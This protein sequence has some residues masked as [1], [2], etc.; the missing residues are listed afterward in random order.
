MILE[1]KKTTVAYR[2]PSCG[3]V[4]KSMVGVFALKAD[5][6]RLKCPCGE[7]DMTIEYKREGKIKLTVP[8]FLCPRPHVFTVSENIFFSKELFALPCGNTGI[9]IAFLGEDKEVNVA[10]DDSDRM[11]AELFDEVDF[12]DVS[13]HNKENVFDDPQILDIILY[14]IGDLAEEGKIHCDCNGDGEYEV[15]MGED[16]VIVKCKKCGKSAEIPAGSTIA[17]NAFL[18][19]DEINLK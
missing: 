15:A 18:H 9:D 1:H 14:V 10:V 8:C 19:A 4:V 17:A 6:M 16:T 2:C 12:E 7:S 13:C 11:L 3:A 5:M